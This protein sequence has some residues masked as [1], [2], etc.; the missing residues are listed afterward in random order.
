MVHHDHGGSGQSGLLNRR[1]LIGE[2]LLAESLIQIRFQ[3]EPKCL[4]SQSPKAAGWH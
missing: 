3:I 2:L 1:P 4:V